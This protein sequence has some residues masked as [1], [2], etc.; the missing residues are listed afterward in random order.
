MKKLL[1]FDL[2]DTLYDEADYLREVFGRFCSGSELTEKD[3]ENYLSQFT[4]QNLAE[5]DL[6]THF[7]EHINRLS[8]SNHEELFQHY[9]NINCKI[10]LFPGFYELLNQLSS[11]KVLTSVLTNGVVSVQA[12]KVRL[13]GLT[14]KV[15]RI[16]YARQPKGLE[17]E[18]PNTF[19]FLRVCDYYGVKPMN[20]LMVGDSKTNDYE[21]ALKLG[22]GAILFDK[23]EYVNSAAY[24]NTIMREIN[25]FVK[26]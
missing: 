15:D 13:L 16:F 3:V 21:P 25:D 19:A 8:E 6:L 12:N 7:L 22:M 24:R 20:C 4:R 14:A 10:A 18:K 2:D 11:A 23:Q 5:K 1:I 9:R 26:M 17:G